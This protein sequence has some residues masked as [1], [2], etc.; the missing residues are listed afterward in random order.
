MSSKAEN[1][2]SESPLKY[3]HKLSS[4]Q[5]HSDSAEIFNGDVE[6]AL[7][8][9]EAPICAHLNLRGDEADKSFTDGIAKVLGIALPTEPGTYQSCQQH[10]LFWLGPDE[11]LLVSQGNAAEIEVSLRQVLAGHIAIVD[12]SGGQTMINLRGTDMAVQTV[13]KKSSVYDFA[14]WPG[15]SGNAGRCAQTTFAKASAVVSN[16][17]DGSF[18]L[19]IRRS[20]ADY[21][22]RWLLDA[23]E[24]FGCRI[25]G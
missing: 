25:E 15:A 12:I 20:F 9:K 14:G 22:A 18:D 21:I 5:R 7:V 8:I 19:I 1:I 3:F 4:H 11:W 13:L 24:E 16:K 23:G 10:S 6:F 17:S 2:N